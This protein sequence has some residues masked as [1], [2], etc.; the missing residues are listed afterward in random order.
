LAD[1]FLTEKIAAFHARSGGTDGAPRIRRRGRAPSAA[2]YARDTSTGDRQFPAD[3]LD[4]V[5]VA[6][7]VDEGDHVPHRAFRCVASITTVS[8]ASLAA[9]SVAKIRSKTP[10]RLQ[11]M[12]RL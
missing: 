9:A 1:A 5:D 2:R 7:R 12:K 11:R 10:I 8:V 4:P 3:R 6:M